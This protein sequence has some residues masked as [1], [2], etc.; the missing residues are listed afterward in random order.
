[1]IMNY[2]IR[3]EPT[4][5]NYLHGNERRGKQVGIGGDDK[6]GVIIALQ[7]LEDLDAVKVVFFR[8]EE[9]GCQ[10]SRNAKMGF[11]ADCSFLLQADRRGGHDFIN[12][13]MQ[14]LQSPAFEEAVRPLLDM[15]GY[16]FNEGL[17]T[18]VTELVENHVGI[19]AANIACGYYEPHTSFEYIDIEDMNRAYELMTDI[20]HTMGDTQWLHTPVDLWGMK[21]Y[22]PF[23]V[24]KIAVEDYRGWTSSDWDKYEASSKVSYYQDL[25]RYIAEHDPCPVCFH[26]QLEWDGDV[27]DYFCWNCQEYLEPLLSILHA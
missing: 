22:T 17:F 23:H 12:L 16:I 26:V 1:M 4:R 20:V 11:F 19:S 8:D 2:I 7:M 21:E 10:G 15:H 3:T 27:S 5:T 14:T 13:G 18:D 6:V 9:I 25:G 24:T